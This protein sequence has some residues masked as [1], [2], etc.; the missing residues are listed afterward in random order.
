M[1]ATTEKPPIVISDN[2]RALVQCPQQECLWEGPAGTGKTFGLALFARLLC[3]T[4]PGIL[5]LIVRQTRKSLNSSF[6]DIWENEILGHSHPALN[7]PRKRSH[8]DEYIFPYDEMEVD[9]V[10]YKGRSQIDLVGMDSPERIMSTQYDFCF[11]IEATEG[12]LHAWDL[13]GSRLRRFYVNRF[14]RPWSLQV[15]DVNPAHAGHWLNV[16]ADEPFRPNPE[17][18]EVLGYTEEEVEGWT[19][20]HRIRTTLKDN[21]KYWD[22][23]AKRWTPEGGMYNMTL[24]RMSPV[25]Q[26]R[27]RDGLWVSESGQVYAGFKHER[28]VVN[29]KLVKRKDDYGQWRLEPVTGKVWGKTGVALPE[30][31]KSR[32]VAYFIIAVDWGFSPD[33]AS[34]GLYAMDE[35]GH[36][37][38]VKGYYQTN[39][40]LDEWARR[41]VDWQ[42]TYDVRAIVCDHPP[43][44]VAKLNDMLGHKLNDL[45]QPIAMTA[46]KGPGSIL[47][48]IET[49]RWAL[50]DHETTGE[51]RL[52]FFANALENE[53]DPELIAARVPTD[54]IKEFDSYRF[55]GR[56]DNEN[57]ANKE[58]PI[59][60]DNHGMDEIRYF[61]TH[62]W[63]N[64][65]RPFHVPAGPQSTNPLLIDL[66]AEDRRLD[67]E[68][69][70][71]MFSGDDYL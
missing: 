7:P 48:G 65:Y 45:G 38:R 53:P 61:S 9:G 12:F 57:Q 41:I 67:R 59:D 47:A 3:E 70:S 52:R 34:V 31:F 13:I 6:L 18:I 5:G 25:N 33:P 24:D 16:R 20:M 51:P 29:G 37:F 60:R 19:N 63:S 50:K 1:V 30:D 39:V 14:G 10:Q 64:Q 36:A 21:P 35:Q 68:M 23:K 22:A 56:T 8:R 46:K 62:V 17:L 44:K 66:D 2:L 43:E 58:L 71:E 54:P 4:Y 27:L 69:M 32:L 15:A 49:V 55:P 28:H 42:K 26:K 40:G 11:F